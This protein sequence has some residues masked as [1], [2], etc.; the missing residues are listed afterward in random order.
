[1]VLGRGIVD[2][3]HNSD[4]WIKRLD[5]PGGKISAGIKRKP[6]HASHELH[7]FGKQ[8]GS[9][10]IGVRFAPG[11]HFPFFRSFLT[12]D[13]NTYAAG[14]SANTCIEDMSRNWTDHRF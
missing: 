13:R 14:R 12:L 3:K 11:E 7:I 10:A 2:F 5:I 6:V 9:P 4:V 1:M 8:V